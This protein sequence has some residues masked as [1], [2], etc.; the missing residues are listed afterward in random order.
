MWPDHV[1][2]SVAFCD[3]ETTGLGPHDRIV[4]FGGIGMISR[5]LAKG[6]PD[7]E[8]LYL[9]SILARATAAAPSKFMAFRIRLHKIDSQCVR[10]R[11][12]A[13]ALLCRFCKREP[14]TTNSAPL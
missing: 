7:L 2:G 4:S 8:H 14:P 11:T 9:G 1:P 10:A 3:V 13:M 6:R 5:D 12:R